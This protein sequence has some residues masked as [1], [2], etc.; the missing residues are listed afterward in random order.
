MIENARPSGAAH[1]QAGAPLNYGLSRP[2]LRERGKCFGWL[3]RT[4]GVPI[5]GISD[6]ARHSARNVRPRPPALNYPERTCRPLYN[7]MPCR[8]MRSAVMTFTSMICAA[9]PGMISLRSA[10]SLSRCTI[11]PWWLGGN[12]HTRAWAPVPS[13][14]RRDCVS[15]TLDATRR[16][17]GRRRAAAAPPHSGRRLPRL[18]RGNLALDSV[19]DLPC[20]VPAPLQARRPRDDL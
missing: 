17:Q 12:E 13:A 8:T 14:C 7:I 2:R 16:V 9:A 1:V 15:P 18:D 11:M 6:A 19:H 3:I 5:E 4:K 10:H 20:L